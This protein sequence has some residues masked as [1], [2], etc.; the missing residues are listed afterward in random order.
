MSGLYPVWTPADAA[1]LRALADEFPRE[2]GES[3][4]LADL[5]DREL[6]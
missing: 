1:E 5:V 4:I 2:V 3:E 6:R